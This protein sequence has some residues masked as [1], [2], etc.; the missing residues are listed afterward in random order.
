MRSWCGTLRVH[1]VVCFLYREFYSLMLSSR[2]S[3]LKCLGVIYIYIYTCEVARWI[4]C[5]MG[6]LLF[7]YMDIYFECFNLKH[8]KHHY[9][10][11]ISITIFIL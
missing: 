5:L 9:S 7:D 11:S 1:C 2:F 3:N 10:S 8:S 4:S 6:F